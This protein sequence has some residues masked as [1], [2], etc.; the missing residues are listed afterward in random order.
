MLGEIEGETG[1]VVADLEAGIG[2][3]LRMSPGTADVVLVVAE[4]SAKAIDVAAR[5][6]RVAG[7]RGDRVVV[8]ANRLRADADLEAIRAKLG[9]HE[10]IPIPEDPAITLADR[11]G[12]APIDI[13]EDSPAVR[14]LVELARRLVAESDGKGSVAKAE[15]GQAAGNGKAVAGRVENE[16]AGG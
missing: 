11:D 8:L 5:A 2:T 4:P 16:K 12:L 6:A 1:I 3:V 13:D 14:T 15:N 7:R 9:D 10:L